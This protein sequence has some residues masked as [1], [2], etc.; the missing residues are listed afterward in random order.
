[1]SEQLTIQKGVSQRAKG[2]YA[3]LSHDYTSL[4]ESNMGK[5]DVIDC[6]MNSR[7]NLKIQ[8]RALGLA[9]GR[10]RFNMKNRP[11]QVA[12]AV[13][14]AVAQVEIFEDALTLEDVADFD[15]DPEC[16]RLAAEAV[17]RKVEPRQKTQGEDDD[18]YGP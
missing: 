1:M 9:I 10:V 5:Q 11:T 7:D 14:A 15:R 12:G 4:L 18:V 2:R 17:G 13:R 3:A 8:V 16:R 6:L